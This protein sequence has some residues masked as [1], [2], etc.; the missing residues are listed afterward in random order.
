[1]RLAYIPKPQQAFARLLTS[2]DIKDG[3]QIGGTRFVDSSFLH[4]FHKLIQFDVII[5]V[6]RSSS[7]VN[8]EIKNILSTRSDCIQFSNY[9]TNDTA[10]RPPCSCLIGSIDCADVNDE[11]MSSNDVTVNE[12]AYKDVLVLKNGGRFSM[13]PGAQECFEGN[14]NYSHFYI[15]LA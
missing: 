10:I 14:Q 1:M 3:L 7:G 13:A 4:L 15:N 12:R 8:Y 9:F 2:D 6:C 5:F 11:F